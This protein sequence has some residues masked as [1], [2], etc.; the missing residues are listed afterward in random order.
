MVLMVM[1]L[2]GVVIMAMIMFKALLHWKTWAISGVRIGFLV[3]RDNFGNLLLGPENEKTI[4][5]GMMM[6]EVW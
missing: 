4:M 2:V 1:V 3:R 5:L 6:R